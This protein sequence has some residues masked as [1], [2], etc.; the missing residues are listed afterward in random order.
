MNVLIFT[1]EQAQLLLSQ[2][3]GQHQLAPTPLT[4]GRWFLFGDILDEPLYNGKLNGIEHTIVPF[5]DIQHLIPVS[6]IEE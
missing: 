6:D 1:N 2:Q 5:E 4:D 3:E